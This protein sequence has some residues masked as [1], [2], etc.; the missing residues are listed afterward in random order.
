V[1]AETRSFYE[2]AVERT[3]AHIERTLDEALDLAAIARA[4]ALS[5]FHFHRVFRG[6]LGETPLEMHRRLRLERAAKR[7]VETEVGITTIAFDAGYE[8]HEAFTRAFHQAYGTSPSAFRQDAALVRA[9]RS[10]SGCARPRQIELAA[11]SSVHFRETTATDPVVRF[12]KGE[13][14][15]HVTIENMPELRV[16][17]VH[18]VGPYPRI[19]EAFARLGAIAGPGG[20]FRPEAAMLAIYHD[21]PETTPADQL[22]SDAGITVPSE[23]P[24]P[25]GLVEMRLPAGR[26]AKTTH[27]GPYTHL[28]DAWS[29]LMG[30]WLPKSGHRVGEGSSYEVYRNTPENAAPNELRTDLYLPI[31]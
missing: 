30:E 1:K 31:A 27:V 7:I 10:A 24:L 9:D 23:V 15:M 22:Q 16:A 18:H 3:V 14:I 12:P 26:Y 19:S 2:T 20:L 25:D 17:T 28:G 29:R 11:P 5:P 8:T 13:S 4:A 21:D 6:M